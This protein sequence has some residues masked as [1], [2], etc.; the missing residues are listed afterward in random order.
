VLHFLDIAV[1]VIYFALIIAIGLWASRRIRHAGDFLISGRSLGKFLSAM[2]GLGSATS[3]DQV[4]SVV[5]QSYRTGLSGIWFQWLYLFGTA[6]AWL[7]A[8]VCRRARVHTAGEFYRLRYSRAYAVFYALVGMVIL[9]LI[10][11][12][13]LL[14]MGET[15]DVVTQG[16]I[17]RQWAIFMTAA[18]FLTYGILGGLKAAAIVDSVQGL[19]IVFL[20]FAMIPFLLYQIGGF[21]G[22]HRV[23]EPS[24][25]S[26]AAPQEM[27]LF[28]VIMF[29]LQGVI[30]T[31]GGPNVIPGYSASKTE[32]DARVGNVTGSLIKRTCTIG[33]VF[34]GLGTYALFKDRVAV[35]HADKAFGLAI[36]MLLPPGLVGLMISAMFAAAM[37][38]CSGTMVF[39]SGLFLKDV[40]PTLRPGREYGVRQEILITRVVSFLVV[41][42]GIVTAAL[43]PNVR[44]GFIYVWQVT[45]FACFPFWGGVVWR[46]GTTVGAWAS[47]LGTFVVWLILELTLK[48]HFASGYTLKATEFLI[49]IP[50]GFL[51]YIF[52]S[53]LSRPED[54][55]KLDH[56]YRRLSTPVGTDAEL[57]AL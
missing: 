53:Y 22:L 30:G 31:P 50:V 37:S 3:T 27:T 12:T 15:I 40:L 17:P 28:V 34:V 25:F 5:A 38:M 35:E 14:A 24:M 6:T 33:W 49:C 51:L 42:V 2:L 8:P 16:T 54:Q 23:L 45:L 57:D 18:V 55:A 13:M 43:V 39:A 48:G 41:L 29:S 9:T 52:F 19:L 47:T 21:N 26:L 56:F 4:I 32:T 1:I 36:K 10:T 46:R 44:E 20:S 11:G 7:L